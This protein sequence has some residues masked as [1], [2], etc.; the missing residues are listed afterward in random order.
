MARRHGLWTS[1]NYLVFPGLTDRRDETEALERL[2][3]DAKVNMIQTRNL[4]I[5]PDW[6]I[7]TLGL[8][9]DGER[10]PGHAQVARAGPRAPALGPAGLLQSTP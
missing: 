7:D 8:R 4:N 3:R 9:G 6:Y 2:A 10:D 1:L 5:D